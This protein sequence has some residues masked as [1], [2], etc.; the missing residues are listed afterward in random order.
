MSTASILSIHSDE[1][2]STVIPSPQRHYSL[3]KVYV[4]TMSQNCVWPQCYSSIEL[5]VYHA[6]ACKP[7]EVLGMWHPSNH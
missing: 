5:V 3:H 7:A 1:E 2:N 6:H 4:A